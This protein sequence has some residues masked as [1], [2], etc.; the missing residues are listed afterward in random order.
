[1]TDL[2]FEVREE[3]GSARL[4]LRG[5]LDTASVPTAN[6]ALE[7]L[8]DAGRGRVIVDLRELDFMDSTG[9]KFLLDGRDSA[10][11]RGV[12]IAIAYDEGMVERVLTVSGVTRVFEREDDDHPAA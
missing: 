4:I 11:G 8:L 9:V 5:E 12:T 3:G 1:L 6:K 10:R 7:D 2:S